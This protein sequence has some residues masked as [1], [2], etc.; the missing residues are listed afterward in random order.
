MSNCTITLK[1]HPKN[2]K[3]KF[4][5]VIGMPDTF[6]NF[7]GCSFMGNETN[8]NAAIASFNSNLFI[9]ESSFTDF[10]AGTIY[11]IAKSYNDVEI[12]DSTIS[13]SGVVGVY[14]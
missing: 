3:S 7:T 2:L 13:N 1:S 14:I 4:V 9:S 11:S 6:A 10:K 5:S 8:Y 12:K